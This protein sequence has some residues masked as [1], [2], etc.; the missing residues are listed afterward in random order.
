MDTLRQR[1]QQY[2]LL[3]EQ[4]ADGVLLVAA[5]GPIADASP[6]R[7]VLARPRAALVKLSL[8]EMVEPTRRWTTP[9]VSSA[10]P[11]KQRLTRA[12]RL[13]RH[14]AAPLEAEVRAR[15]LAD[16]RLQLALRDVGERRRAAEALR[17]SE[18]RYERLAA[19]APDA[20]VVEASGRVVFANPALRKLLG[21]QPSTPVAGRALGDFL[22]PDERLEMAKAAA[23]APTAGP[24]GVRLDTRCA[25][26]TA[27]RPRW[28]DRDRSHLPRPARGAAADARG[29]GGPPGLARGR[30][31]RRAHRPHQRAARPRPA[32]RR[33]RAGVPAPR[34]RRGRARGRRRVHRP[35]ARV[36]RTVADRLCARRPRL[37]HCVR[38]GDTAAR[39]AR[40]T[41]LPSSCPGCT[42]ARTR[43]RIAEKS[44]ARAAQALPGRRR[45]DTP[46]RERG[47][48]DLPED[49]EDAPARLGE[50]SSLTA[51]EKGG[52]RMVSGAPPGL[53]DGY[54]ALELPRARPPG[55]PGRGAWR[56]TAPPRPPA[57]STTSRSSP[58]PRAGWSARR[59]SSAGSTRRWAWSFRTKLPLEVRLHRP[60]SRHRPLDPQD[61]GGASAGV[62]EAA[63]HAAA[64][65]QHLT[66]GNL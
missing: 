51:R 35:D 53:D 17:E 66:A 1:D 41:P 34:P 37:A 63:A 13:R 44:P 46:H 33:D 31:P 56:S 15:R 14:G 38:Q 64:R 27:P 10:L 28:S 36:G 4:A 16:G 5:D 48:R 12:F 49:G 23:A 39:L 8:S 55:R 59:R 32:L 20:I 45:D 7:P 11:P 18:E 3:A 30:V 54:D 42:T 25:A 47:G 43:N 61:G 29:R 58:S 52:D 26:S 60:H 65:G 9:R 50:Q 62:A 2:R 22:H 19:S 21:L 40:P 57:S 24:A 6:A